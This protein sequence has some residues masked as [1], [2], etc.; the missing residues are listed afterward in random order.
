[1]G[2]MVFVGEL[3]FCE[4]ATVEKV[5]EHGYMLTPGR[6]VGVALSQDDDEPFEQKMTRLAIEWREHQIHGLAVDQVIES[7]LSWLGIEV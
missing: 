7:N 3:G 5:R 6:F 2:P 1:M 4:S